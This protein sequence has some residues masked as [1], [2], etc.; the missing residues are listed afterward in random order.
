[1]KTPGSDVKGKAGFKSIWEGKFPSEESSMPFGDFKMEWLGTDGFNKHKTKLTAFWIDNVDTNTESADGEFDK[2]G[3][4][5][6]L[7]GE[8][9]DPRTGG[10]EVYLW[11]LP[12][13]ED[14]KLEIEMLDADKNGKET[15]VM[16][17]HGERSKQV[18]H[19]RGVA[20]ALAPRLLNQAKNHSIGVREDCGVLM[21]SGR[22]GAPSTEVLLCV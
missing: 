2:E 11:R 14:S 18:P 9:D 15:S 7:K 8:H 13:V 17:I 20:L 6:S 21:G 10:R 16:V 3:K 19:G 22:V 1:L 4:D 12:V 5:L